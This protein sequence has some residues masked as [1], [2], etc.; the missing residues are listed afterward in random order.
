MPIKLNM[1]FNQKDE[2]KKLGAI[3]IPDRC[4]C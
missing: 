4:S 2:A 3:W 1:P